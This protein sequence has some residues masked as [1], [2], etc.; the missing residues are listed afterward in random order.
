M[1][2]PFGRRIEEWLGVDVV[3]QLLDETQSVTAALEA[4]SFRF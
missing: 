2:Q 3:L 1:C 4:V